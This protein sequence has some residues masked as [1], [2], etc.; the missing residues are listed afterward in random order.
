[1]AEISRRTGHDRVGRCLGSTQ[2]ILSAE[3]RAFE[4]IERPEHF[5]TSQALDRWQGM[6]VSADTREIDADGIRTRPITPV[7]DDRAYIRIL[8]CSFERDQCRS[9]RFE[10]M[11]IVGQVRQL[12][13]RN[14]CIECLVR[15]GC[16]F[17]LP[18]PKSR[19]RTTVRAA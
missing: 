17:T 3:P 5:G 13:V 2:Q 19:R 9:A 14:L 15:G 1:M 7:I 18:H 4:N 11:P 6:D 12:G 10:K 16:R 8:E